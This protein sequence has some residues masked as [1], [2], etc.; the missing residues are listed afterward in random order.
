VKSSAAR[1]IVAVAILLLAPLV[2][3]VSAAGPP[4]GQPV[5]DQAVYDEAGVFR[6]ATIASAEA[7]I[8]AI[9][10]RTGAEVVVYSRVVD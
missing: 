2:A 8:D 4:F 3:V 10:A 7:T 1:L 6:P 9:E 5:L